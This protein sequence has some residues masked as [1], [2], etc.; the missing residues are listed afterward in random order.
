MMQSVK[1]TLILGIVALSLLFSLAGCSRSQKSGEETVGRYGSEARSW[2]IELAEKE[3]FRAPGT[4][5]EQR[6]ADWILQKLQS[7]GLQPEKQVFQYTSPSGQSKSSANIIV[8]IPGSG[9]ILDDSAEAKVYQSSMEK[10]AP[11]PLDGRFLI[12]GAHYDSQWSR[13]EALATEGDSTA[14]TDESGMPVAQEKNLPPLSES[15]GIDDNA[16]SVAILLQT[17]QKLSVQQ[18]ILTVRLIFFGAGHHQ[19]AGAS[20]Y[21][22]QLTEEERVRCDGAVI[23]DSI[24]AGDKV[25]A[26]A[27]LN[28]VGN[29]GQKNY[30]MRRKLYECTDVYYNNLLLTRN[31]FALYTNQ[32]GVQKTLADKGTVVY[33][34]WTERESDHTPFDRKQIPVV[35][36]ESGDY[37]I[38]SA[39]EPLKESNDPFFSP[40]S[41]IIRGSSYDSTQRLCA[42]FVPE[43]Q[44]RSDR[45][46]TSSTSSPSEETG[47][48][49]GTT[50]TVPY[51]AQ[52]DRL[53]V[54]INNLTFLLEELSQ[55]LP[56]GTAKK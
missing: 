40:V 12:Y 20:F 31:G 56:P 1:K 48:S 28:S 44:T 46:G 52:A 15:N 23:L 24:Y 45:F 9:L 14:Q 13:D 21:A 55:T 49:A 10:R 33:R 36:I 3:P 18:P 7:F 29:N 38:Q 39:E 34:E 4:D 35:L 51:L 42:Y 27:G 25:Y 11:E 19:W 43:G 47:N 6:A 37:D 5:S 54:R 30:G 8:T 16:S 2:A 53:E 50:E 32:S 22:N 26:H 17:A 41:G